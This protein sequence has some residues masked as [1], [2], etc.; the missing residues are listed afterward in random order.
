[1]ELRLHKSYVDLK[2]PVFWD[3]TPRHDVS[4]QHGLKAALSDL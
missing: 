4:M 3:V 2:I 1:M